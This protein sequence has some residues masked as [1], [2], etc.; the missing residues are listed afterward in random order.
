MTTKKKIWTALGMFALVLVV[1]GASVGITLAALT[2]TVKS[3]FN[4]SYQANNVNATVKAKYTL[5]GTEESIGTSFTNMTV[6]TD[7]GE[8]ITFQEDTP[9]DQ[10][11]KQFAGVDGSITAPTQYI[12]IAFTFENTDADK[13]LKVK[14]TYAPASSRN[15]TVEYLWH[16]GDLETPKTESWDTLTGTTD[17]ETITH[18]TSKT[19]TCWIRAHVTDEVDGATFGGTFSFT[20]QNAA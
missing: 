15:F 10:S 3:T 11:T 16:D 18:T 4:V 1:A 20:L 19:N 2:G 14:L 5:T 13:D 6:E 7:G 17:E 9:A 8:T 12:Y